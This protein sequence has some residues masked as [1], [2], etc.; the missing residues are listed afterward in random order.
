M[1]GE[2]SQ[3]KGADGIESLWERKQR[4]LRPSMRPREPKFIFLMSPCGE[5]DLIFLIKALLIRQK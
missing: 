4:K 1:R 3:R 5:D 2:E